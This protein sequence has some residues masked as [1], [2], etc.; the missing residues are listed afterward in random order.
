MKMLKFEVLDLQAIRPT[1]NPFGV[2]C[3]EVLDYGVT[4]SK[5]VRTGIEI[6]LPDELSFMVAPVQEGL[7]IIGWSMLKE[8]EI[9]VIYNNR[10]V[11][12]KDEP[13]AL[14][15]V[16]EK[17]LVPVR[18]VEFAKEGGRIVYGDAKEVK[19]A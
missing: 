3:I 10:F 17:K 11:G 18:F 2:K 13:F 5:V 1:G 12:F 16:V 4:R 19:D 7:T 8:L 15:H 9:V 14:V 6:E